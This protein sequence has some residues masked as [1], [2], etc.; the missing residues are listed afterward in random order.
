MGTRKIELSKPG[1]KCCGLGGKE[2]DK[3][4]HVDTDRFLA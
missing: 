4:E 1:V 2:G 3:K